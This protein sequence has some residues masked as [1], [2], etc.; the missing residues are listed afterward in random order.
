[1]GKHDLESIAGADVLL[2]L[3]DALEERAAPG[4][5]L[6]LIALFS[7]T[8]P[9]AGNS[10]RQLALQGGNVLHRPFIGL[11]R[12]LIPNVG[13]RNDVDLLAQ[14]IERQHAIEKHEKAIGNFE[15]VTRLFGQLLQLTHSIV[16]NKAY[17]SAIE[18]WEVG[19]GSGSVFAQEGRENVE[20]LSFTALDTS[21]PSSRDLPRPT[22]KNHV[23]TD[24]EKRVAPNSF[25]A[26]YRLQQ[27]RLLLSSGDGQKGGDRRKQICHHRLE[28]GY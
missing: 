18:G 10:A 28:D 2:C 20:E 16:G 23:R 11:F 22:L 27:E 14:M 24:S 17:G 4:G 8:D 5:L 9:R 26:F 13:N 25:T 15:I 21:S 19:Q 12:L 7:R 3:E 1:M 6:E